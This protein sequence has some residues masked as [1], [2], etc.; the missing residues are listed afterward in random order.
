MATQPD[1]FYQKLLEEELQKD[2]PDWKAVRQYIRFNVAPPIS[3][4]GGMSMIHKVAFCGQTDILRWCVKNQDVN[5]KNVSLA[6]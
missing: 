5:L 4:D 3:E 2:E 6:Y 1:P